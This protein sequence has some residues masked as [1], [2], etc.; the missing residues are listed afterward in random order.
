[1]FSRISKVGNLSIKTLIF[2][3]TLQIGDTTYIDAN[4]E[5][6]AVQRQ[7]E[8][9]SGNEGD[10]LP[11]PIFYSPSVY[12]PIYE[13]VRTMFINKNPF[14]KVNNVNFIGI[15]ASSVISVGNA[16]HARMRSRVKHI[17]QL[18]DRNSTNQ[19]QSVSPSPQTNG[20]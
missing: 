5:V 6:F 13:P 10:I 20:A 11:Y 1:M 18:S 19:T 8:F 7:E 2:S 14:I 3:S 17:R 12:L 16:G 9:F 15:S 4:S